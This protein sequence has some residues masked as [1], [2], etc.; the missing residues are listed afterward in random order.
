MSLLNGPYF[1]GSAYNIVS[2]IKETEDYQLINKI[3]MKTYIDSI[4]DGSNID[5]RYVNIER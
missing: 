1:E 4:I 5:H 3:N 2:D